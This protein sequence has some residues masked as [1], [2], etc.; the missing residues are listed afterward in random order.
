MTNISRSKL[1]ATAEG[2]LRLCRLMCGRSVTFRAGLSFHPGC[3]R[4][5]G[6]KPPKEN[7]NRSRPVGDS[8]HIGRQSRKLNLLR[9]SVGRRFRIDDS[10][11]N[12]N[13]P[14]P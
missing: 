13:R 2:F 1:S 14:C 6:A 11:I 10:T 3:A 9:V 5:V 4:T 7:A 8:L 12:N